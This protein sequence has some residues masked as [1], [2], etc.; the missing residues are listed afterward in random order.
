MVKTS[1]V[2]TFGDEEDA[3]EDTLS[4]KA[5]SASTPMTYLFESPNGNLSFNLNKCLMAKTSEVTTSS[6]PTCKTIVLECDVESLKIKREI[7]SL[8]EFISNFEGEPKKHVQVMLDRLA[9]A[10]D[11]LDLK[12]RFE[13]KKCR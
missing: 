9:H 8:D 6:K 4:E 2:L 11:I 5:T 7:I 10:I 12:E 3:H 1:Q 13:K